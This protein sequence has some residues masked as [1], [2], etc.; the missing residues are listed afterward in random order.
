MTQAWPLI[1]YFWKK[2]YLAIKS[3]E[4]IE[5]AN[6]VRL[7]LLGSYLSVIVS[8]VFLIFGLIQL[9]G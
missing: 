5:F 2:E 6:R 3:A 9:S 8:A 7:L 4:S 1:K